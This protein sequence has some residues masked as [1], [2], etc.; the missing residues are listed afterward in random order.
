M[1]VRAFALNA[2]SRAVP[3]R[4]WWDGSQNLC[5]KPEAR[6]A[7]HQ[8]FGLLRRSDQRPIPGCVVGC[9]AGEFISPDIGGGGGTVPVP[10]PF[11]EPV[12]PGLVP[13]LPAPVLPA[14]LV[15]PVMPPVLPLL[16]R[17]VPLPVVFE[18]ETVPPVLLPF[19]LRLF[20][21]SPSH[22]T[23]SA[24]AKAVPAKS[25]EVLFMTNAP[26]N[27]AF[28][29]VAP[30]SDLFVKPEKRKQPRR[31]EKREE[32]TRRRQGRCRYSSRN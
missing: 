23:M 7:S 16:V 27:E 19:V 6:V 22:P 25:S 15:P 3:R 18:G 28:A 31:C 12:L 30:S 20:A 1:A 13:V 17:P 32:Q 29:K 24:A 21:S 10:T 14:P 4:R 26:N 5:Q 8:A 9:V 2:P 11:P